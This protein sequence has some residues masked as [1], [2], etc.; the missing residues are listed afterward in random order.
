VL[1]QFN[2]SGLNLER[3]ERREGAE[4]VVG[5]LGSSFKR[6]YVDMIEASARDQ[7]VSTAFR[8]VKPVRAATKNIE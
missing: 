2:I 3:V 5:N 7:K 6:K 1:D 4:I 8:A